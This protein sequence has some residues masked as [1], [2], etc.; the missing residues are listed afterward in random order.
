MSDYERQVEKFLNDYIN[1]LMAIDEENLPQYL[2]KDADKSFDGKK[3]VA[4]S[5]M[6]ELPEGKLLAVQLEKNAFCGKKVYSRGIRISG[7]DRVVVS[8]E[9]MWE[10]GLG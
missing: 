1:S 2:L 4:N 7:G 9:E 8:Q 6:E 5:W 3:L 10:L